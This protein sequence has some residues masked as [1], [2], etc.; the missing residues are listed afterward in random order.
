MHCRAQGEPDALTTHKYA[1]SWN[2]ALKVVLRRQWTLALRDRGLIIGRLVQV[3]LAFEKSYASGK[4]CAPCL[5]WLPSAVQHAGPQG[6]GPYHRAAS[7]G[8]GLAFR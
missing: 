2:K 3:G 6:Q 5:F 1:L 8:L 4:P 7:F